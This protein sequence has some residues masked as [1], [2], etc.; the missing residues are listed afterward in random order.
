M[1]PTKTEATY[2]G[3]QYL[4]FTKPELLVSVALTI[5]DGFACLQGDVL[6]VIS[7]SDL[8]RRR[9]R[10]NASADAAANQ[11]VVVVEDESV[12]KVGDVLTLEDGTVVGTIDAAGINPLNHEITCVANLAV[13]VTDG[14]A[15]LASDGSQVAR[16]IA[17]KE[18]DGV[19]DTVI[20]VIVA[21]PLKKSLLRGLDDSAVA[22]LGGAVM[23]GDL[24]KF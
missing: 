16:A 20:N 21:G 15:I 9:S 19:G 2:P 8:G 4:A 13:A 12:F 18:S 14:D 24:F 17:D 5:A 1:P 23:I 3:R 10:S 6:G 11:K 22:E 7:A